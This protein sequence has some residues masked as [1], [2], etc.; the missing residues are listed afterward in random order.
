[1]STEAWIAVSIVAY[2]VGGLIFLG[3]LLGISTTEQVKS[4]DSGM[5]FSII[6]LW[7]PLLIICIAMSITDAAVK[8]RRRAL[9][10]RD[11]A[12]TKGGDKG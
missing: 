10:G 1:M 7:F 5:G 12:G 9:A 3:V 11:H 6:V 8:W 2:V 4:Y